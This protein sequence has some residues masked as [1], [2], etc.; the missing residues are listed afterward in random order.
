M[1]PSTTAAMDISIESSPGNNAGGR[2]LDAGTYQTQP[3]YRQMSGF[4]VI[5]SQKLSV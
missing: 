4:K 1:S 2:C 5:F 3:K